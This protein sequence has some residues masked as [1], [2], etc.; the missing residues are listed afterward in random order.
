MW[1]QP[2]IVELTSRVGAADLRDV[3]DQLFQPHRFR[4]E[5]SEKSK[6]GFRLEHEGIDLVLAT[7]MIS[8]GVDVSRLGMMVVVGQPKT[9]AEYIQASS[10]VGRD[11]DK[12]PGVVFTLSNWARPRDL[13]HWEQFEHYHDTFY[14]NVEAQSVTPFAPRALDRGATGVLVSLLRGGVDD[15]A[16][17]RGVTKITA[18]DPRLVEAIEALRHRAEDAKS[19]KDQIDAAKKA[20]QIRADDLVVKLTEGTT[21]Y[22]WRSRGEGSKK[23]GLTTLLHGAEDVSGQQPWIMPNSLRN[24][25]P[26]INVLIDRQA[27]APSE[28]K[29]DWS[30]VGSGQA[31]LDEPAATT[32]DDGVDEAEAADLADALAEDATQEA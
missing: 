25:E 7:N 8:V 27:P 24:T 2:D 13:S 32:V 1:W 17:D 10:R 6:S 3:L 4:I 29:W 21:T 31:P 12:A 28:P 22:A 19:T 20:A 30:G 15:W 18:A 5:K 23:E 11:Y 16:P 9:T 14:R 26:G